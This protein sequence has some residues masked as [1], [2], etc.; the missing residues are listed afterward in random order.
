MASL[1]CP[2]RGGMVTSGIAKDDH[3]QRVFT[4]LQWSKKGGVGTSMI[5]KNREA[6]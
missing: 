4:F 6:E 2:I 3:F 5:A 1:L